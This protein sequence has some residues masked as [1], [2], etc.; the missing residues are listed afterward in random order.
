M[1]VKLIIS[2][3]FLTAIFAFGEAH[4][5]LPPVDLRPGEFVDGALFSV[6]MV[7]GERSTT[8]YVVGKQAAKIK[9]D[10]LKLQLVID[11]MGAKQTFSLNRKNDAFVWD[12]KILKDSQLEIRDESGR[13]EQLR[14]KATP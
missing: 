2:F 4:L 1:L 11:P 12:Q 6:K 7:P 10:R 9:L 5:G 8:F 13:V 3:L 14:L